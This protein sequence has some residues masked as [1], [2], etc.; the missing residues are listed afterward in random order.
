MSRHYCTEHTERKTSNYKTRPGVMG[1]SGHLAAIE[2]NQGLRA[3]QERRV[4]NFGSPFPRG[5]DEGDE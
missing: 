4:E 1:T 2:G 3:K 5:L